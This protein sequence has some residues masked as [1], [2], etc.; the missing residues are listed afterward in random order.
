MSTGAPGSR[1]TEVL[2]GIVDYVFENGVS[3][4]SLR[5]LAEAL[6]TS[7][8]MLLYHFGTK[9]RLLAEVLAAARARQYAM[10]GEWAQEGATLPELVRRYWAWAAS[11]RS[12]PYMRLFFEVYGLA[13][14]GRPGTEDV[15]PSVS[16]H[17]VEFFSTAATR[18]G[19]T[20]D[21]VDELVRLSLAVMRGL[22][23]DLLATNDRP[24]LD[25]DLDRFLAFLASQLGPP[26]E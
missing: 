6:N 24:P 5:P 17:A 26:Q 7:P 2:E 10:L 11:D 8:R 3:D 12:R 25:A 20:S 9:E 4:L 14:Q 19:V 15:L 13:V 16:S 22:L 18:T 21:A 1:K 23:F